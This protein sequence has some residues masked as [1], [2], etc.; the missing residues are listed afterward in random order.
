M[1]NFIINGSV[2]TVMFLGILFAFFATCFCTAKFHPL[3]PKD[4]GRDFAHDGKL[5]AGKPR[6]AGFIFILV[7]AASGLIF[8]RLSGE[9]VIYIILVVAAMMMGFLD[10]ASKV[11]WGE[12]KKGFLD[13]VIAAMVAVTFLNYNSNKVE[14]MLTGTT[15]TIPAILFGILTVILVWASI[16]V[17]NCSDGVDGLSGTLTLVTIIS[18]YIIDIIKGKNDDFSYLILLF[19]VCILG[20]LWF[21]ATPSKLMMG[22]AGSRAMGL[23]ISIAVLKTGSPFLYLLVALVLILDGGLG[24][25]KVSLLRFLKI[26]IL[27][28]VRTPLHD[29]V[30]KVWGWS[31]T[32]TVFRF[33]IIQIVVSMAAVY[34][35]MIRMVS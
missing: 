4:I 18:I 2:P 26:R 30:R 14:I 34:L 21:N 13:F 9:L 8:A 31:N 7:F 6:G 10:D 25:L 17:T 5:S 20:Y 1:V 12:Y 16:N 23:F 33:T 22:D 29:H 19:A 28:N 27:K 15:I 35:A 3:L 11:P 24:L 32:Q